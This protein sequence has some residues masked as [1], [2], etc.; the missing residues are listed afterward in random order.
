MPNTT[1]PAFKWM[2]VAMMMRREKVK[3]NEFVQTFLS[4]AYRSSGVSIPLVSAL[5]LGPSLIPFEILQNAQRL[6]FELQQ[7]V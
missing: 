2:L 3:Y 4:F 1:T 5:T 7:F 6:G